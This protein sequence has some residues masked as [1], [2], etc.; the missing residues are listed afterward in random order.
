MGGLRWTDGEG[1]RVRVSPTVGSH[2]DPS[3]SELA[4][5]REDSSC[6]ESI[7]HAEVICTGQNLKVILDST[8]VAQGDE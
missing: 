1:T 2:S 6:I 7:R 4:T 8:I 3:V 5:N